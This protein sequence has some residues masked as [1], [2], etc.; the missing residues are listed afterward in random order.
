[1]NIE[2]ERL[3]GL[4][5]EDH[6]HYDPDD[7]AELA[8][9]DSSPERLPRTIVVEEWTV[10]HPT[11][12]LPGRHRVLEWIEEHAGDWGEVDM[13]YSDHLHAIMIRPEVTEAADKLLRTIADQIKYHM[14]DRK[15]AEH[16]YLL[17]EGGYEPADDD[18]S[19]VSATTNPADIDT[20]PT[21]GQ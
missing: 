14:A 8:W 2:T 20:Y 21:G 6:L 1:M 5:G 3:Y 10:K 18:R 9:D 15:V 19:E 16:H 12:H 11:Q 17:T 13:D 4:P 7:A